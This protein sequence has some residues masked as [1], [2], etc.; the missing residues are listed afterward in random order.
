V[1]SMHLFIPSGLALKRFP[2]RLYSASTTRAEEVRE[3]S[4]VNSGVE[5]EPHMEFPNF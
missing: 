4:R 2:V 5:G 1:D 3:L